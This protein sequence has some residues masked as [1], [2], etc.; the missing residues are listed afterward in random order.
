VLSRY[1]WLV[2]VVAHVGGASSVPPSAPVAVF[3]Q[4]A[5]DPVLTPRSGSPVRA[6]ILDAL[7]SRLKTKSRFKVDH[8]R[9]TG[10]WAFVRATEVVPLE[11][12]EQQETD[13]SVAALLEKAPG[14]TPSRWRI[15]DIWTLPGNDAKPLADFSRR[16]KRRIAAE[17]LPPALLPE[18]L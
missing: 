8:I 4:R 6:A 2:L 17:R 10:A 14:S 7:R 1:A 5:D 9:T 12:G 15:V 18:D 13:L 3:D 16:V 11:H